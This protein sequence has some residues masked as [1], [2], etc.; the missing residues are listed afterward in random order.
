[1]FDPLSCF[2]DFSDKLDWFFQKFS[3]EI[4]T[5]KL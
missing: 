4:V 3:A 2:F 1:M 5:G